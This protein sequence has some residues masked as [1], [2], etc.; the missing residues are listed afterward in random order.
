MGTLVDLEQWLGDLTSKVNIQADEL[1]LAAENQVL[2]IKERTAEGVGVDGQVF[3]PYAPATKKTAPVNLRKTG[4]MMDSIIVE[5]NENQARIGFS[6]G[7][8]AEKAS[9]HNQGTRYLP[10][11]YFFGVGIQDRE[12]I[13]ADIRGSVFR[14]INNA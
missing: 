7:D 11:R 3:A 14:R 8:A 6:D 1:Q 10:Q 2:R 5:A 9:Y 4:E 12:E 13:L